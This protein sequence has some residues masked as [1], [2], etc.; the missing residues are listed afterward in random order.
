MLNNREELQEMIASV[1]ERFPNVNFPNP[2]REPVWWGRRGRDRIDG[3]SAIVD[4]TSDP[5]NPVFYNVVSDLYGLRQHEEV[6]HKVLEVCDDV[7][8]FGQ[9]T[10]SIRLPNIAQ[11]GKMRMEAVFKDVDYTI[12]NGDTIHPKISVFNS[13]DLGWKLKGAFGAFQL[14]C[15]NGMIIGEK[16]AEFA[17]RHMESLMVSELV[18]SVKKG[19]IQFSEQTQQWKK[20]AELQID[21]DSYAR[22]WEEL[23]FGEKQKEAIEELPQIGTQLLLPDALDKK[24]LTLWDFNGVVTQ[25]VTHEIESDLVRA[26]KEPKIARTFANHYRRAA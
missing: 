8:E 22:V 19:M 1:R 17:K 18:E 15:S 11:G 12:R 2:A 7:P 4:S 20:W 10:I 24:T 16:W 9:P 26:E 3:R 5:E 14:V 6:V 13:I 21:H 23:P 25:F